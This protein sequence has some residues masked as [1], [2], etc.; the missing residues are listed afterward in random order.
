MIELLNYAV[1]ENTQPVYTQDIN[2]KINKEELDDY[3]KVKLY[4]GESY[5]NSLIELSRK[6]NMYACAELGALEFDGLISGQKNYEKS[7]E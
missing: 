1:L 2:I 3:L 5:I 7:Y 4:F 6:N